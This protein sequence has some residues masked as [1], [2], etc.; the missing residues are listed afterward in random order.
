[1]RT[2]IRKENIVLWGRLSSDDRP[3]FLSFFVG[4][5]GRLIQPS[6]GNRFVKLE[7]PSSIVLRCAKRGK[8]LSYVSMEKRTFRQRQL[9][10]LSCRPTARPSVKLFSGGRFENQEPIQRSWVTTPARL[11]CY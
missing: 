10:Q 3:V 8:T 6:I 7:G 11:P 2:F 1:V 5:L 9:M 4:T